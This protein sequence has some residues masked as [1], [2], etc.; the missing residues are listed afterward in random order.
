MSAANL[1]PTTKY[2]I[3]GLPGEEPA[4][5]ARWV[6]C[7]TIRGQARFDGPGSERQFLDVD[8][9]TEIGPGALTYHPT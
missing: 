5:Y 3:D 4:P 9:L 6:Y 1:T 8:H 2:R 7:W